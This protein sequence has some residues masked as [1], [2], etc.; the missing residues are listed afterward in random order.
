MVRFNALCSEEKAELLPLLV[1][2]MSWN[3]SECFGSLDERRSVYIVVNVCG[4]LVKFAWRY[5]CQRVSCLAYVALSAHLQYLPCI[6]SISR[7]FR[8]FRQLQILYL[9]PIPA[10]YDFRGCRKTRDCYNRKTS[11]LWISCQRHR[12][13][14]L[15]VPHYIADSS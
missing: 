11:Y 3:V 4:A 15:G 12:P 10:Y 9:G 5:M 8:V 6:Q 14:I 13:F 1:P 2:Q 7:V